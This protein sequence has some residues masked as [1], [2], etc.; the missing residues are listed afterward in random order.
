M[1]GAGIRPCIRREISS[2][3]EGSYSQQITRLTDKDLLIIER[4]EMSVAILIP[5]LLLLWVG[6]R[7]TFPNT[8]NSN[9]ALNTGLRLFVMTMLV[10]ILLGRVG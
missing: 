10:L 2:V 8:R 6:V 1:Y 9:L 5:L 4:E 7:H 3:R